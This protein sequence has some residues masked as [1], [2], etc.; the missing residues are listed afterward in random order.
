MASKREEQMLSHVWGT[1]KPY[2]ISVHKVSR[3]CWFPNVIEA[4]QRFVPSVTHH[5]NVRSKK[6]PSLCKKR[7]KGATGENIKRMS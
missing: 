2:E 7:R 4:A 1:W 5:S 6:R 3:D